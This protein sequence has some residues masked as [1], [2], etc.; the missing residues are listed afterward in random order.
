MCTCLWILMLSDFLGI[1]L[2]VEMLSCTIFFWDC[3]QYCIF[4][5]VFPFCLMKTWTVL[6]PYELHILF[7][8]FAFQWFSWRTLGN[9]F[10][11]MHKSVLSQRYEG[12]ICRSS[13]L[14]VCA[15][16]PIVHFLMDLNKLAWLLI[17]SS[18]LSKDT[19]LFRHAS[20]LYFLQRSASR[21]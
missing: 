9:F 21:V 16:V 5:E 7:W 15:L 14:S 1:Y 3:I 4:Y 19:E 2:E 13:V 20:A 10:P 17:S 12:T 6:H 8:T 18:L 11:Y